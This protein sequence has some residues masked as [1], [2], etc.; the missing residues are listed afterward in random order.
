MGYVYT[1]AT[2]TG[3][4][5]SW[6]GRCLV[7]TG[8]ALSV[9]TPAI[10]EQVGATFTS[11]RDSIGIA[12]GRRIE[13]PRAYCDVAIQ[14]DAEERRDLVFIWVVE[15]E[16]EPLIGAH[17]LQWLGLKVDPTTERVEIA[18]PWM[19]RLGFAD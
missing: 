7:D 19:L 12:G 10:A 3:T 9:L 8:A 5:G 18:R 6:T 13:A 15:G 17:T 16:E 11:T 4:R 2:F 1:V 14:V